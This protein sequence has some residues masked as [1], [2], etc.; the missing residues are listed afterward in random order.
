VIQPAVGRITS[1]RLGTAFA[2]DAHTA[3]TAWHCV[4]DDDDD[5]KAV[6]RVELSFLGEE[7]VSAGVGRGDPVADWA[8][9]ELARPLSMSHRPIPLRRDVHA[10][11]A[12]RC[13]GFPIAAADLGYL[14]ILATVSGETHPSG[15]PM[16]TLEAGTVAAGLDVRGLSG[17][18]VVLRRTPEEAVGVVSRRLMDPY[19]ED[20][21]GG[22]LFACPAR[23][24]AG[25]LTAEDTAPPAEE[26]SRAALEEAG[27]AEDTSAAAR[28]GQLLVAEGD[29][30]AAEPWL[31]QAAT[32]GDP[33]A[34][35]TLGILMDPDGTLI[36][37]D[38]ARADEAL[39]WFRRAATGGDVY[40]TT[41]MGI[42]LR[43]RGRDDAALP[44]LEEAIERGADA[45]AAHTL[46][47]MHEDRGELAE[48]ERWERFAARRG[49]VRAAYDLG[50]MLNER[51]ERDEA[52]YWLR[53]ATLDPD[54]VA[55][56]RALGV[57]DA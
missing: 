30:R 10:G 51:G 32:G 7:L 29:E 19:G 24:V 6:E 12:C 38:P 13:L 11:D 16:L 42:R 53:R 22:V 23:V 50:R 54:A 26:P 44:W 25:V 52:I 4:R 31:R 2:V 3:V 8:V 5:S 15:V 28:L 55:L 21:V 46:A 36:E 56:L 18:P 27:R 57:E 9:L 14:P 33:A 40:G 34:A 43:Q 39:A 35:Y 49:D 48:A 37:R 17:G 20:Q 1:P 47:R 41:T 45:M